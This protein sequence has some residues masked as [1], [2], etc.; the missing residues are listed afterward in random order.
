MKQMEQK[1]YG[2][3]ICPLKRQKPAKIV[4]DYYLCVSVHC[5]VI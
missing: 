5:I 3:R 4:F 2:F 1:L